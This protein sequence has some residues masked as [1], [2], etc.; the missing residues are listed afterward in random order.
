VSHGIILDIVTIFVMSVAVYYAVSLNRSLMRARDG[1]V[2]LT[3]LIANLSEALNRADVAVKTM[4]VTASDYELSLQKQ[5]AVS[6]GLID[7][8]SFINDTS[9]A[10]ANRLERLASLAR[11]T[12]GDTPESMEKSHSPLPPRPQAPLRAERPGLTPEKPTTEAKPATATAT[13]QEIKETAITARNVHELPRA[14]G[15]PNED[16]PRSRAERELFDALETLR[17]GRPT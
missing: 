3:Q 11:G 13:S 8:L 2:E 9:N 16:Q 15:R 4:K 12:T 7:E 14:A 10:L 6:R 17:K 5:I 1:R